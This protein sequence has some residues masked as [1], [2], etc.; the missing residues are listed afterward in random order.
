MKYGISGRKTQQ[1]LLFW[2]RDHINDRIE[3]ENMSQKSTILKNLIGDWRKVEF[4]A[5]IEKRTEDKEEL[6]IDHIR[7]NKLRKAFQ[8]LK[9]YR[10]SKN[11]YAKRLTLKKQ[12]SAYRT[13]EGCFLEW[14]LLHVE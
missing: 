14:K 11:Y 12:N 6:L 13:M 7:E 2:Y 1:G 10:I 9:A 5:L 8:Y 4:L 3:K